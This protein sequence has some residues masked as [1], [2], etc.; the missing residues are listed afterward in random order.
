MNG[1]LNRV[2][3]AFSC[4]QNVIF[5]EMYVVAREVVTLFLQIAKRV[6]PGGGERA[7]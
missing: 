6:R 1:A 4:S 3:L 5:R 7:I 2:G